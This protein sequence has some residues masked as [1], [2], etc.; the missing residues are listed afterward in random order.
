MEEDIA[1]QT[2]SEPKKVVFTHSHMCVLAR[3]H[4]EIDFIFV[5]L[6]DLFKILN[7]SG[8]GALWDQLLENDVNSRLIGQ[9]LI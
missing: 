1:R 8:C 4:L 9:K 7:L 5:R 3:K 6:D 2:N